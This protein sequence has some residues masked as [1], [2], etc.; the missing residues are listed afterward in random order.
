MFDI[1]NV[2]LEFGHRVDGDVIYL[3]W[4]IPRVNDI[5][6]THYFDLMFLQGDV[7]AMCSTRPSPQGGRMEL[8]SYN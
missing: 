3:S 2:F 5:Y 1:A 6:K 8:T 4:R 7:L